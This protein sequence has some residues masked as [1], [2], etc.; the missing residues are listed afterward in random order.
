MYDACAYVYD[1]HIHVKH[2]P[3]HMHAHMYTKK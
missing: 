1:L 3:T 2:A